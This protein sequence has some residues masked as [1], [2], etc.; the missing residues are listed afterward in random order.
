MS[1]IGFLGYFIGA[2]ISTVICGLIIDKLG[3]D[4]V[5]GLLVCLGVIQSLLIISNYRL[6]K[7][8]FPNLYITPPSMMKTSLMRE[9][10]TMA[11]KANEVL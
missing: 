8:I 2:N 4:Y 1:S 3:Y 5:L 9:R 7:K 6:D 10:E 11:Q